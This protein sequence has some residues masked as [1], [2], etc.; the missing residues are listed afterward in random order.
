MAFQALLKVRVP[1][2]TWDRMHTTVMLSYA[3]DTMLLHMLAKTSARHT[4]SP[5]EEMA[6]RGETVYPDR[7]TSTALSHQ[8][9]GGDRR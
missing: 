1:L 9:W 8:H 7:G 6:W 5:D 4:N 3:H 2:S